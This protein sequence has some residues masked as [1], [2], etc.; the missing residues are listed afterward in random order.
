M[1]II[2]LGLF[3]MNAEGLSGSVFQMLSHGIVS[4]ALFMLVGMIYER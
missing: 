1:G 4:G 2:M 3:A